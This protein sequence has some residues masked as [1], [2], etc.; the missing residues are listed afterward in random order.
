MFKKLFSWWHEDVLL[1]QALEESAAALEKAG[2]MFSFAMDLLLE[3]V[4]EEQRVYDMDQEVNA[5]QID[6]RKKILEHLTIS[7]EQDVTAS[8]VLITIIVDVERIGDFAK[9]IVEL[10][11]MSAG[12][13][14]DGRYVTE[15][16][17]IRE[18]IE[19]SLPVAT[20]AFIEAD[21][22]KAKGLLDEFVWVGHRC[23]RV[24]EALVGDESLSVREA[25]AYGLLFRYLKRVG[26]HLRNI[27]SSVVNPFHRLGYKPD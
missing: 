22:D 12:K 23:D 13:L 20:R 5:L 17:N 10:H 9:N 8:L 11:H 4:G 15:I 21:A 18:K 27:S 6:I 16:R 26:A 3:G 2:E 25:V 24:L 14:A 7:P 19:A 1:K